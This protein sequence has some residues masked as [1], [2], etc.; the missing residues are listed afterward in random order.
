MIK[1]IVIVF[2]VLV[3]IW[4]IIFDT[5]ITFDFRL[6]KLN[7]ILFSL[8]VTIAMVIAIYYLLK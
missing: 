1:V 6:K 3:L 5:E 4:E 2:L 8:V 7:Q